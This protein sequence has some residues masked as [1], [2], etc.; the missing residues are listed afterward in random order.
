MRVTFDTNALDPAA[1]PERFPK[2]PAQPNYFKVKQA[3]VDG[4]IQGFFSETI[5][6]LEGIQKDDRVAVFGST[7]ISISEGPASIDQ[8]TGKIRIQVNLNVEQPR[9]KPL[10]AEAAARVKTAF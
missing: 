4:R 3:I 10:H 1:R 2:D 5:I 9:Y 6:S 7:A 8:D